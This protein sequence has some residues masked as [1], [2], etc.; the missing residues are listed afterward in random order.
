MARVGFHLIAARSPPDDAVQYLSLTSSVKL[1][2]DALGLD[3]VMIFKLTPHP[4]KIPNV[5]ARQV[6]VAVN[7]YAHA[8][9]WAV[10]HRRMPAP[11]IQAD[12]L[13]NLNDTSNNETRQ[14]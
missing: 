13:K 14:N 9:F 1:F 8:L 2:S 6:I 12:V 4:I 5:S 11:W 3:F 10:K 7:Q